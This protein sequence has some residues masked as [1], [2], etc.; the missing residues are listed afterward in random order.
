M[1]PVARKRS[2]TCVVLRNSN[3]PEVLMHQRGDI[4]LWS[5]PG[6]GVEDG[7][8]WESAAVRE[9]NEETGLN[10]TIDRLIGVFE[11]PSLGDVKHVFAAHVIGGTF[12]ISPPETIRLSWFPVDRLPWRR[13]P[14]VRD[15]VRDAITTKSTP[16]TG[17]RQQPVR[18]RWTMKSLYA[19]SDLRSWIRLKIEERRRQKSDQ[20]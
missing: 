18:V 12:R 20:T 16:I 1:N 19:F 3:G 17:V 10:V 9:V 6:G 5:L 4:Y 8:T 2:V 15:D 11:R 7:E 14:W 13:M